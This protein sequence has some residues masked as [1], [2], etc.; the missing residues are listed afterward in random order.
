MAK[1]RR[2]ETADQDIVEIWT[3]IAEDNPRAA[4]QTIG[5]IEA[6]CSMLAGKPLA[7]RSRSELL[8]GLR[9]FPVDN[10][11]IFYHRVKGG[12]SVIRVLHAARDATRVFKS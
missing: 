7:G 8:P 1:A 5:K 12:I 4:D 6:A 9:S 2:T 3:Y 11:L 10:Y